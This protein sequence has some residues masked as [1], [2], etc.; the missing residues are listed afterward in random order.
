MSHT[1]S[2]SPSALPPLL[3]ISGGASGIGL[4]T[5]RQWLHSR[6]DV[7]LL[8]FD[9][10][11]LRSAEQDLAEEYPDRKI[12]GIL[13]DVTNS[14]SVNDAF[15]SI[16]QSDGRLDALVNSAGN[17]RPTTSST[18]SD[19]DWDAV[20]S[21]HLSGSMRTCR[22]A[23]AL[24]ASTHGSIVNLSS[25]AGRV[26]MPR[27]A[28]YTSVKAGLEGLTRTLAVEWASEGIRVNSVCPGYVQTAMTDTLISQGKLRADLVE[29]RVPLSRFAHPNEIAGAI[30]FLCSPEASYITGHSL[31]VDGGMTV[32]G[33]WY[34]EETGK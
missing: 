28:S 2:S 22:S 18:M 4:A 34:G 31:V 9:Q 1:Q 7:V 17:A 30:V 20:V 11:A 10:S 26:G 3:A 5:A 32:E 19:D 13:T 14:D 6:G 27:R 29:A 33:D 25:V 23:Y 8:D 16:A 12:R 15:T 21:V 24:L